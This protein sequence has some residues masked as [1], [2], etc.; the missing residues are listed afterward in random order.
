MKEFCDVQLIAA[1]SP[2]LEGPFDGAG[3]L[4]PL[5]GSAPL[6]STLRLLEAVEVKVE[7]IRPGATRRAKQI[8]ATLPFLQRC[9]TGRLAVDSISRPPEYD[10]Q[11]KHMLETWLAEIKVRFVQKCEAAADRREFCC[12]MLV[13]FPYH[14]IKRGVTV[15]EDLLSEKLK[16]MLAELGFEFQDRTVRPFDIRRVGPFCEAY[17]AELTADWGDE[18]SKSPETRKETGATSATCPICRD[19]RPA[20]VLVPCGHVVCRHCKSC[21]QLRQC[22]MCREDFLVE[23]LA[24]GHRKAPLVSNLRLLEA[25]EIKVQPVHIGAAEC[26]QEVMQDDAMGD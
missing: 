16:G 13:T 22:P 24:S 10:A 25:A 14:L 8:S 5:E 7:P 4:G 18:T 11:R 19:R 20:V 17:C 23:V 6:V 26:A 15:S 3:G 9:E 2:S 1:T 12:T 21:Q